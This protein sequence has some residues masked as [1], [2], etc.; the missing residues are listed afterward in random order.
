MAKNFIR[1]L[2]SDEVQAYEYGAGFA[3]KRNASMEATMKLCE[4]YE[5][6]VTEDELT[7]F[8]NYD[9]DGLVE[10]L[11]KSVEFDAISRDVM[12]EQVFLYVNDSVTLES[13]VSEIVKRINLIMAERS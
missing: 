11:H 2:L 12:L 9:W 13:A 1:V 4:F 8:Q 3:V 6:D 5:W 7:K 10:S